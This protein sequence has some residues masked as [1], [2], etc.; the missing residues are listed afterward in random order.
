G[1]YITRSSL[2]ISSSSSY[3]YLLKLWAGVSMTALKASGKSFPIGMLCITDPLFRSL[4]YPYW[5]SLSTAGRLVEAQI[6]PSPLDQARGRPELYR[7]ATGS[8]NKRRSLGAIAGSAVNLGAMSD[9]ENL[10][11]LAFDLKDHPVVANPE[12][13]VAGQRPP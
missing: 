10:N 2:M 3:S 13:P 9:Q 8:G 4:L 12:L 1:P 7:R 6:C 5:L 11:P